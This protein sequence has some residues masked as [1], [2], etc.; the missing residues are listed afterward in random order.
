MLDHSVIY[1]SR[2]FGPLEGL[3]TLVL[4]DFR[5]AQVGDVIHWSM[6]NTV[7]F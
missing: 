4:G 1:E 2:S 3:K 6:A 7:S 5:L